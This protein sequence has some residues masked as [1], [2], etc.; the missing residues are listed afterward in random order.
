MRKTIL[1]LA[2]IVG[3]LSCSKEDADCNCGLI[4]DDGVNTTGYWVDIR[5]DCSDNIKRWY[6]SE[7]DWVNAHP[8]NDYCIT[9][10]NGW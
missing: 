5:S 8:G 7:G 2:I 6:L 1:I 10:S 4:T 3:V 9:N